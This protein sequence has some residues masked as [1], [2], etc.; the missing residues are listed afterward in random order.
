MRNVLAPHC[1]CYRD[2]L[3]Y[4]TISVYAVIMKKDVVSDDDH[5]YKRYLQEE[6]QIKQKPTN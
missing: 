3:T 6:K 1:A 4:A 5:N 2:V